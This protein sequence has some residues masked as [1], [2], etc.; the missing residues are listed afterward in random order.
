MTAT[1]LVAA[2]AGERDTRPVSVAGRA[3]R[4]SVGGHQTFHCHE[5]LE[6]LAT[7]LVAKASTLGDW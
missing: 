2:S 6:D 4:G 7:D 5:S 1:D 3:A